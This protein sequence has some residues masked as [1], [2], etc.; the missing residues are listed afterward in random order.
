MLAATITLFQRPH[1]T[2]SIH[3]LTLTQ[4]CGPLWVCTGTVRWHG[5]QRNPT[6]KAA[7]W[8]SARTATAWLSYRSVRAHAAMLGVLPSKSPKSQGATH[9]DE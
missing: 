7:W 3:T 4:R 2:H 8:P 5:Q 9:H 6:R 1:N